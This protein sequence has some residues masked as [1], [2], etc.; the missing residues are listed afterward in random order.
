MAEHRPG[1]IPMRV[2][3][4]IEWVEPS[5][6]PALRTSE[7]HQAVSHPASPRALKNLK[8]SEISCSIF[9]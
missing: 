6:V 8:F 4:Q 5:H 3:D 1:L 7:C 2:V 9:Y